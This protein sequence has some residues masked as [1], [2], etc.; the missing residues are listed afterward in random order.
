MKNKHILSNKMKKN[1]RKIGERIREI[2]KEKGLTQIEFSK[3]L[4]I[5]QDKLSKY[6]NGRVGVPIEII[7][8]IS[9]EFKISLDWLLKGKGPK[10]SKKTY[11]FDEEIYKIAQNLQILKEDSPEWY[12]KVKKTI[13]PWLKE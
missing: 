6:E 12:E 4:G 1:H 8:R 2:R 11:E 3:I 5:T 9:D 7:L 10:I 13:S